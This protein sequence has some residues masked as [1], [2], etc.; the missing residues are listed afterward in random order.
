[1]ASSILGIILAAFR[2]FFWGAYTPLDIPPKKRIENRLKRTPKLTEAF[3]RD[4]F[5]VQLAAFWAW[6]LDENLP[7]SET[8][9]LDDYVSC[10]SI[11]RCQ[12]SQSI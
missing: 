10:V 2:F 12:A 3:Y 6:H 7:P 1:M 5:V 8:R 9:W 4:R 11:A